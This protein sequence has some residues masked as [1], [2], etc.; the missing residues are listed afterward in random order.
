MPAISS[1]GLA[2]MTAHWE[3]APGP[4]HVK[5]LALW[6]TDPARPRHR[7]GSVKRFRGLI[8]CVKLENPKGLRID[9]AFTLDGPLERDKNLSRRFHHCAERAQ[10]VGSQPERSG[11]P[12][13][14]RAGRLVSHPRSGKTIA[15]FPGPANLSSCD[16][17][18]TVAPTRLPAQL[19]HAD[20]LDGQRGRA[21]LRE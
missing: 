6:R 18:G 7:R 1:L 17:H 3:F 14:C 16:R 4:S 13:R 2:A 5:R 20:P 21:A 12:C 10:G 15:V 11:N 9:R 19:R 8:L